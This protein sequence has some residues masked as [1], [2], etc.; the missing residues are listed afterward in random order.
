MFPLTTRMPNGVTNAAPWQTF[1]ASG[2]PDPTWSQMD[3]DDFNAFVAASWTTT[4]VGT[5]AVAAAAGKGGLATFA[6]TAGAADATYNQRPVAAFVATLGKRTFFKFAGSL[7]DIG[8]DVFYAGLIA[9]SATPLAAADG[10]YLTK[11]SGAATLSL[12]HKIG[13]VATTLALPATALLAAATP[14]ELGIYINDLG[15][16]MA[17]FNPTTGI[18]PI[19]AAAGASR[20]FA[21]KLPATAAGV[22]QVALAPSF[23]LVNASAVA[24]TLTVDYVVAATER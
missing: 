9:T 3:V 5:G 10:I 21:A 14:F 6:T 19:N 11:A 13:G 22:T 24:R 16:I 18:N 20:G 12:V 7:S 15:D 17:Y 4:L 1:G 2:T 8:S 23:G